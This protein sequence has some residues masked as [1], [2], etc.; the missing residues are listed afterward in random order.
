MTVSRRSISFCS[1]V[2]PPCRQAVRVKSVKTQTRREKAILA[3][4]LGDVPL[5]RER[6]LP[7]G[8]LRQQA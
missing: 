4:I 3:D 6:P 7:V 2:E 1:S 8:L 5:I